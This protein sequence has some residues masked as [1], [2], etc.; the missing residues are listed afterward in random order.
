MIWNLFYFLFWIL[1]F[2][3]FNFLFQ[4]QTHLWMRYILYFGNLIFVIILLWLIP[5]WNR[6]ILTQNQKQING[7]PMKWD[8]VAQTNFLL[9]NDRKNQSILLRKTAPFYFEKN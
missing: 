9:E 8:S 5:S 2:L 4:N 6:L 3:L 7:P 1:L